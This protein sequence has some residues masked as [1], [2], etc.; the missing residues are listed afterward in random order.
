MKQMLNDRGK[1]L[2]SDIA[3]FLDSRPTLDGILLFSVDGTNQTS[4]NVSTYGDNMS[5]FKVIAVLGNLI[6]ELY[7]RHKD[8][9]HF[10]RF[11]RLFKECFGDIEDYDVPSKQ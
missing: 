2:L 5:T 7:T 10:E 3:E 6:C 9:I 11:D 4:I 8:E 1:K